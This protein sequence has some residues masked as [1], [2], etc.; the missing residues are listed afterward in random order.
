VS[1]EPKKPKGAMAEA[2]KRHLNQQAASDAL[3]RLREGL[4]VDVT[5]FGIDRKLA[6]F[7]VRPIE[8]GEDPALWEPF[9]GQ[10]VLCVCGRRLRVMHYVWKDG[11]NVADCRDVIRLP[12]E[13]I[14]GVVDDKNR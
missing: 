1:K 13:Q 8:H 6:T 10:L 3:K 14:Y 4:E 11:F 5:A 12:E 9:P 2:R 7:H